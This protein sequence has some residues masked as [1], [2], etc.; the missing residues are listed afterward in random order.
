M[1]YRSLSKFLK[2]KMAQ[3][4]DAVTPEVKQLTIPALGLFR[5]FVCKV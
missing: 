3:R 1:K 4:M 2:E 5:H